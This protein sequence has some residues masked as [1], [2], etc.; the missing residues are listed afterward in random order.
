MSEENQ[1]EN[2][3]KRTGNGKMKNSVKSE[4]PKNRE[5]IISVMPTVR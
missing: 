4:P 2:Q 3:V 5:I 1:E